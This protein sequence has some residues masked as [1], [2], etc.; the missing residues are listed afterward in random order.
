MANMQSVAANISRYIG[1]ELGFDHEQRETVRYGLEIILGSLIKALV[2]LMVS[3]ILG[4]VP[5]VFALLA[6]S[7]SLRILSG[8]THFRTYMRCLSFSVVTT[9]C[10]SF[11]AIAAAPFMDAPDI[12]ITIAFSALIGLYFIHM[13][14]PADNPKKPIKGKAKQAMYRRLSSLFVVLWATLI[15]LI[16]LTSPAMM[17]MTMCLSSIGGFILQIV[18]ISPLSYRFGGLAEDR[19]DSLYAHGR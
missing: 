6:T 15:I 13:W 1:S 9:V 8:G 5:Y 17:T 11:V 10:I 18:S 3:L 14:A 2:I 19:L 7:I 12:I 4:I 16:T